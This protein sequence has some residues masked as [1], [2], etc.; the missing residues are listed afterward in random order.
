MASPPVRSASHDKVCLSSLLTLYK[1]HNV[2]INQWYEKL[3]KHFQRSS[4][5]KVDQSNT[6]DLKHATCTCIYTHL[7]VGVA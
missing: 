6:C 1:E 3:N 5:I 2:N 7:H 4:K